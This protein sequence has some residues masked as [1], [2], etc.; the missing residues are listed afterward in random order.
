MKALSLII[1]AI[2]LS[3]SSKKDKKPS[4][5]QVKMPVI[6]AKQVPI[7]RFSSTPHKISWSYYK[8]SKEFD[9]HVNVLRYK[10][11]TDVIG[12]SCIVTLILTGKKNNTKHDTISLSTTLYLGNYFENWNNV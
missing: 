2:L 5:T 12:D 6:A 3:C 11:T 4:S 10:D 8:L 1:V 7:S 9:I